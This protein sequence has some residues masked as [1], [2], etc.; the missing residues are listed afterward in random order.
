MGPINHYEF[1][2]IQMMSGTKN[3]RNHFWKKKKIIVEFGC[4]IVCLS[5][6]SIVLGHT[7][8]LSRHIQ[9]HEEDSNKTVTPH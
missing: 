1:E 6:I 9:W 2:C 4:T 5:S 3:A 7:L 8:Q